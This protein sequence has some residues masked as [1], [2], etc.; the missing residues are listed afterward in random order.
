MYNNLFIYFLLMLLVA[1]LQ[2]NRAHR[3]VGESS[4]EPQET[5]LG[6]PIRLDAEAQAHIEKHRYFIS[7]I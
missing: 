7:S 4:H 5:D 3:E 6:K 1:F 2:L